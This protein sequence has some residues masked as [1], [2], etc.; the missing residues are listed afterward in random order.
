[1]SNCLCLC[2]IYRAGMDDGKEISGKFP[3][4]LVV[5]V[6]CFHLS[7]PIPSLRPE[8]SPQ[9]TSTAQKK[10]FLGEPEAWPSFK[11]SHLGWESTTSFPL[12]SSPRMLL[13]AS[14]LPSSSS[15]GSLS[16]TASANFCCPRGFPY[17]SSLV[18]FCP[19]Q[20][21]PPQALAPPH[22]GSYTHA[23][24][25]FIFSQCLFSP[26]VI[27]L[28]ESF[29]WFC[30]ASQIKFNPADLLQSDPDQSFHLKDHPT[31]PAQNHPQGYYV[32]YCLA[33]E[34]T[35]TIWFSQWP[36]GG[37]MT[38]PV[39]AGELALQGVDLNEKEMGNGSELGR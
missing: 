36:P 8:I 24:A 28:P 27:S 1:M 6:Q 3:G 11:T 18:I 2:W 22:P 33:S 34:T 38:Q 35:C 37:W 14:V 10:F 17:L 5:R 7:G 31:V 9:A 26:L 32:V 13:P 23:A 19:S 21:A 25:R 20:P 16:Q 15:S 39:P 30:S 4:C 29:S 12:R